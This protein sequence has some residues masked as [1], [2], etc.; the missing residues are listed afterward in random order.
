MYRAQISDAPINKQWTVLYMAI[1]GVTAAPHFF[2]ETN[3]T[4]ALN[5]VFALTGLLTLAFD[6]IGLLYLYIGASIIDI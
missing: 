1:A 5:A 4:Q 6:S 2:K 3:Q